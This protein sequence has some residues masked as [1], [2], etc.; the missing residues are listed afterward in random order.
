LL[1]LLVT[2]MPSSTILNHSKFN[3]FAAAATSFGC[4]EIKYCW[5][6]G[7]MLVRFEA[8]NG[9]YIVGAHTDSPCL[10]LKP[11]SKVI[12]LLIFFFFWVVEV[13]RKKYWVLCKTFVW[14][15]GLSFLG[16]DGL[17]RLRKVGIW[18]LESKHMEVVCGIHGSIVTWQ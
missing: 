15:F 2:S 10:K 12:L 13:L 16:M 3:H 6:F 9:F 11:V 14:F 8:G 17:V 4:L 5:Y 1:S 7:I 18:R